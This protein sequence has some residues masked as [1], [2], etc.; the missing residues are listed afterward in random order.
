MARIPIKQVKIILVRADSRL[1]CH[2]RAW[3]HTR[4]HPGQ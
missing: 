3:G 1:D 2:M 4:S